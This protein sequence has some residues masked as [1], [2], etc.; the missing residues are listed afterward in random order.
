MNRTVSIY[1]TIHNQE[2]VDLEVTV[3][4]DPYVPARTWGLP[5]D[6]YPEEGGTADLIKAV[7]IGPNKEEIDI[8]DIVSLF[9]NVVHCIQAEAYDIL[10]EE[11][12]TDPDTGYE[13]YA[14]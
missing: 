4:Y 6:C 3:D 13:D 11:D 5:E 10:V 12:Y 14:A 9:P 1:T 2:E 8:T 7:L